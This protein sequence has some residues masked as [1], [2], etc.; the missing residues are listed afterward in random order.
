MEVWTTTE[1]HTKA[2]PNDGAAGGVKRHTAATVL[3][4]AATT[5]RAVAEGGL[6]KQIHHAKPG[7]T[8]RPCIETAEPK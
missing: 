1:A 5:E 2:Q 7:A 6:Q 3:D 4:E 8:A